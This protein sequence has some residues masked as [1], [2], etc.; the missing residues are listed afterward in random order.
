MHFYHQIYFTINRFGVLT[1]IPKRFI[2]ILNKPK[3]FK[4]GLDE[5]K[6]LKTSVSSGAEENR[7]EK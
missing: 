5:M 4:K 6:E 3:W 2:I 1:Y 7:K